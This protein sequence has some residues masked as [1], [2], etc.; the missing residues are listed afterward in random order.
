MP[1][2]GHMMQVVNE[3]ETCYF[4]GI[5]YF[6]IILIKSLSTVDS[7]SRLWPRCDPLK[8]FTGRSCDG[9]K[10]QKDERQAG[11]EHIHRGKW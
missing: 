1:P 3:G 10:G 11:R 8:E 6:E 7:V 9:P 4:N 5:F 2:C